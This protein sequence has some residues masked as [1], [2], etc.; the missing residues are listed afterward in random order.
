MAIKEGQT[1]TNA[2]GDK[3]VFRGGQWQ[4]LEGPQPVHLPAQEETQMGALRDQAAN[5]G[6][7]DQEV[8]RFMSLYQKP[9]DSIWNAGGAF[10]PINAF[11]GKVST[12]PARAGGGWNPVNWFNG[13]NLQGM[14]SITEKLAPAQ[15]IAGSG[16]SSDKDVAGFKKGLPSISKFY[17]AN[18]GIADDYHNQTVQAQA[19]VKFFE[20]W[21]QQHGTLS[22]ASSAFQ[23]KLDEIK[24]LP[25][26]SPQASNLVRQLTGAPAP[27][28]AP[29]PANAVARALAAQQATPVVQKPAPAAAAPA[30]PK[31]KL[32][33]NPATG[34]FE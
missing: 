10:N 33:Y 18:A 20:D 27:A 15:R 31:K 21:V 17:N 12:G 4:P 16:S 24:A 30:G 11:N 2:A 32:H 3:V 25:N 5:M 22:G 28:A 6:R 14:D 13:D 7:T 9:G 8:Q 26:G 29:P 34:D 23:Q 1:A 19:R